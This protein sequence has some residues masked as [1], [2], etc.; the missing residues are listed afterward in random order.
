LLEHQQPPQPGRI[1]DLAG[2]VLV[3]Q[4][5]GLDGVEVVAECTASADGTAEVA[6]PVCDVRTFRLAPVEGGA[7]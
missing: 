4:A 1:V 6:I 3:E 7:S 5:S 2:P